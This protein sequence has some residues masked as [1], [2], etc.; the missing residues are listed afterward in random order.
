M[1]NHWNPLRAVDQAL[2]AYLQ[3]LSIPNLDSGSILRLKEVPDKTALP[4]CICAAENATRG[5]HKNWLVTGS[6]VL[7][8]DLATDPGNESTQIA[9]SDELEADILDA[10]ESEIPDNDQP[11]PLAAAIQAAAVAATVVDADKLLI[12]DFM[13]KGITAGFDDDGGWTW[14]V[15]FGAT[16]AQAI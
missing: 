11:Q 14:T 9:D 3:S 12:V 7:K 6:I 15:D 8:T 16:V 10:F 5:R 13:L 1:A 2:Q 4:V